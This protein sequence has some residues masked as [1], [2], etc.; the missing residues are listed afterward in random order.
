MPALGL[1]RADTGARV[2]VA[3][4]DA[5]LK[6]SG[7]LLALILAVAA[8]PRFA[9]LDV[10]SLWADELFT[11]WLIRMPFGDM[12]STIPD[13]EA[14]P[15][16]YYVVAW[17]WA[18]LFGNGEFGLRSLSALAG[19]STV[20]IVYLGAA[21]SVSTRVGLTAAA[22]VATNPFLIWY[23]QEA[24]AYALLVPFAALSFVS[25]VW[26]LEAP[27]RRNL[28]IWAVSSVLALLTHYFGVFLV[29]PETLALLVVFG[30][31]PLRRRVL[32]YACA[33]VAAG[34]ALVPLVAHQVSSVSDPGGNAD[35]SLASRIIAVP[36][37]FL[38]GY[39]GPAEA[40]TTVATGLLLLAGLWFA[41]F[42]AGPRSRWLARWAVG[43][44]ALCV[45]V[46]VAVS[47][48]GVDYVASRNMIVA[49][50][51]VLTAAA[52]GF[53]TGKA[54]RIAGVG[55]VLISLA[56]VVGVAAEP[57]YQRQDWRG[58]AEALGPARETRALAFSP[59]FVNAGPFRVYYG[60]SEIMSPAGVKVREIAVA[61]LATEG[62]ASTGTPEPPAMT[63]RP[64]PR[65]FRLVEL[66][67]ADTY[68][69]ARYR[70]ERAYHVTPREVRRLAPR[71][72]SFAVVVQD[73]R[74]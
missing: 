66:R 29:G 27:N 37:N 12:L 23:S 26:A 71:N 47:V 56:V 58:G 34:L 1:R 33:P 7:A 39:N 43:G 54:G 11:E 36:K 5:A 73:P 3:E 28:T 22:V 60:P 55:L 38:V 45:L 50:P 10:Q 18:K 69:L 6:Q 24:R 59:A 57:R 64:A 20:A 48:V 74:R 32:P 44:A 63:R 8:V 31:G 46:P 35:V 9:T 40:A 42:R 41:L 16:L 68:S 72:T 49:L 13:T 70:P 52:A 2:D 65:G 25:F 51:L 14:T 15:P 61:A 19:L 17:A 62:Q 67:N 4:R 53:V 30:R 21:R